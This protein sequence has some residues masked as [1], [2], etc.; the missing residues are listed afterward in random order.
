M[1]GDLESNQHAAFGLWN[2]KG[3]QTLVMRFA[4][5]VKTWDLFSPS[6][7]IWCMLQAFRDLWQIS[8]LHR[9]PADK[10]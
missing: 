2:V 1:H 10:Q 7:Y 3:C 4:I 5:C 6:I 8:D 9:K